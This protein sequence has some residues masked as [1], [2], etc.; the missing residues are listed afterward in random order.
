MW[1]IIFLLPVDAEDAL[2]WD[3]RDTAPSSSQAPFPVG[4]A[5]QGSF[6]AP[7]FDGGSGMA[8]LGL[9]AGGMLL[10]DQHP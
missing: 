4:K 2:S 6:K 5:F 8:L 7:V 1:D 3:A 9:G 10:A